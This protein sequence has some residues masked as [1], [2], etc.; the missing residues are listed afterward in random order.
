MRS[1]DPRRPPVVRSRVAATVVVTRDGVEVARARVVYGARPAADVIDEL[2]RLRQAARRDGCRV[3]FDGGAPPAISALF[4]AFG[5]GEV[6]RQAE[7][8][9]E[10]RVEEEV[11][12]DEAPLR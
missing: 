9:E 8:P 5:L 7:E 10:L 4:E 6:L 11:E 1:G 12:P 3:R 2:C